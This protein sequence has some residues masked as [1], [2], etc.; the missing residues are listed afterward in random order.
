VVGAVGEVATGMFVAWL[1]AISPL[2]LMGVLPSL[3]FGALVSAAA[4]VGDLTESLLKRQAGMKDSSQLLPGIGGMLDMIDGVLFAAP[5]AY[6][7]LLLCAP[8]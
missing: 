8:A 7:V 4:M 3:V 6:F 1:L 2:A 5:V